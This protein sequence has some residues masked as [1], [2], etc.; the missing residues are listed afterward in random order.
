MN[1]V[2]Q[3]KGRGKLGVE[4]AFQLGET[5]MF[6]YLEVPEQNEINNHK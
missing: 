2:G 3:K 1:K 4:R 6:K 5:S